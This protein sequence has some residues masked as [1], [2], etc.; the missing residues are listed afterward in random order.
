MQVEWPERYDAAGAA[1]WAMQ[2][3][4]EETKHSS[5]EKDGTITKLKNRLRQLEDAVQNA[6]KEVDE[7]EARLMKEHEMLQ[8]VS[9]QSRHLRICC[10]A[11]VLDCQCDDDDDVRFCLSSCCTSTTP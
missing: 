10:Y 9:S 7:K 1:V 5:R 6:C 11:L 2:Q 8:D 3:R 4:L